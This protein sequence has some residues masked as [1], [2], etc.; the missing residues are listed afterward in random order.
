M[1]T[2][3]FYFIDDFVLQLGKGTH[4][5]HAAGHTLM[6]MLSNTTPNAA[7]MTVKADVTEITAQNGYSAG[8]ADTAN[9]YTQTSGTGSCV[10]T[11]ITWTS[12][13]AGFG[14]FRYAY[15]YND[16][17]ASDNLIGYFDYGAAITP[18]GGET[19]VT[20]F[21]TS[22]FTVPKSA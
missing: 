7:T 15:L 20:D 22:M 9:D 11:D 18:A 16:T 4:Q 8:G 21:G 19:F 2:S 13:G 10:G 17:A 6:L 12:S 3:A 14:P 5:L 1:A